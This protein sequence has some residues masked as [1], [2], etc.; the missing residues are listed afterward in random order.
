[1]STQVDHAEHVF[2]ASKVICLSTFTLKHGK[3]Q[4]P[5]TYSESLNQHWVF[6]WTAASVDDAEMMSVG[7]VSITKQHS[8]WLEFLRE[9]IWSKIH[10]EEEMLP[11]DEALKRHW[12]RACWVLNVWEQCTQNN[13]IYPPLVG[14][15]WNLSNSN[16][17]ID[18]DSEENITNIRQTV[19]LMRKGC[20][21]KTG[22]KSSRCKCKM[23]GN[24][25]YGCK[26]IGCCN[27]PNPT[28]AQ[29]TDSALSAPSDSGSEESES[30][31]YRQVE[32]DVEATMLE[33]F[34]DYGVH[35]VSDNDS[36]SSADMNNE[37]MV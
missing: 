17:T 10:Y 19:A 12:N 7:C 27:L 4:L 20:G 14:N 21:C 11:S 16:L 29:V 6:S 22:C 33:V 28:P 30:E 36:L 9:R 23:A 18:W 8:A 2:Y 34:G 24:N 15:G 13:I 26:C 5:W 31:S 37:C 3:V 1:M 25:C 32:E 35:C